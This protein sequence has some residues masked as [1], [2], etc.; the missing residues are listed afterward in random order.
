MGPG[1]RLLWILLENA[2]NYTFKPGNLAVTLI[3]A[4]D[5]VSVAVE[6]KEN[7]G[8]AF[9]IEF[10]CPLLHPLTGGGK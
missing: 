7:A 10:P 3:I 6:S 9:R 8:S 4:G 5:K 1:C 2:A